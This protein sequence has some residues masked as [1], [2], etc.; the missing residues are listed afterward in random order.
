VEVKQ[1]M[2]AQTGGWSGAM[3]GGEWIRI[4]AIV[5]ED[6]RVE[7]KQSIYIQYDA[8]FRFIQG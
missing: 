8:I 2:H 1:K 7:A 3:N 4:Q 5:V 6:D